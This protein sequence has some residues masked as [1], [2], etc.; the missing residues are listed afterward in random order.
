MDKNTKTV[1]V[2]CLRGWRCGFYSDF[3]TAKADGFTACYLCVC[4]LIGR[5]VEVK[6]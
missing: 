3:E 5:K 1:K 2:G 6:R 4:F